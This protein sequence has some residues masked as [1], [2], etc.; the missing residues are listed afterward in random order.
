MDSLAIIEMLCTAQNII[1][2]EITHIVQGHGC[3]IVNLMTERTIKLHAQIPVLV[4]EAHIPT[5]EVLRNGL[6]AYLAVATVTRINGTI[7]IK[8]F[9]DILSVLINTCAVRQIEY[10]Y[11]LSLYQIGYTIIMYQTSCTYRSNRNMLARCHRLSLVGTAQLLQLILL[12]REIQT[13]IEG[14]VLRL[15][16]VTTNSQFE[17]HISHGTHIGQQTV[18]SER[19]YRHGIGIKHIRSLGSVP[20]EGYIETLL[21]HRQVEADIKCLLYLPLQIRVA[22]GSNRKR[23]TCCAVDG[24]YTIRFHQSERGIR[25]DSILITGHTISCTDFEIIY[26]LDFLHPR[27]VADYPG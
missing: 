18:V 12:I 4:L 2:W 15:D 23:S 17:S 14:E 9:D 26:L 19:R 16:D 27:L 3:S 11:R 6:S 5:E 8:V 1:G 10:T 20:V 22:V 25:I 21:E 7:I 24:S 13:G